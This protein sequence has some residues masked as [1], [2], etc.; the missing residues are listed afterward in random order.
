V[1]VSRSLAVAV[2]LGALLAAPLAAADEQAELEKARAAYLAKNYDE[3]AKR[4]GALVDPKTGIKDAT[5]LSQAR[6]YWGAVLIARGDKPAALEVFERLMLDDA[7]FEPDP[8]SFSSEIINTFID[9]RA[10]LRERLKAA[11]AEAA[12]AEAAKK[13]RDRD[14]KER[15]DAW[16]AKVVENAQEEHVT[17]RHSRVVAC[18]PFGAGQLQN[19]QRALGYTLLGVEAALLAGTFVTVPMYGYA[20]DRAN[21][22][23]SSRD[24]EGKAQ[25]YQDRAETIRYVNLGLAGAFVAVAAIG[26]LQANL[27][28]IPESKETHRRPLPSLSR[29][30][31]YVGAPPSATSGLAPTGA[32]VGVTG[33]LF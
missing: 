19:G 31:P 16:L 28:F 25:A 13:A 12:R 9:V 10:K 3:A 7:L 33:L 32:M 8:L 5:L 24:I 22:E 21:E 27:A 6:M 14:A 15:Y 1:K 29:V 2:F 18:V 11:A 30:R 23:A 17:V 26:V 4:F 20:R